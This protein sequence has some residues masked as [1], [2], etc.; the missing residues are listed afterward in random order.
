VLVFLHRVFQLLFITNVIPSSLILSTLM[1]EANKAELGTV[2]SVEV[3]SRKYLHLQHSYSNG[4]M[5]QSWL[6][7]SNVR[8]TTQT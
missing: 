3:L 1:M 6:V 8:H 4:I 7:N 5:L 2:K